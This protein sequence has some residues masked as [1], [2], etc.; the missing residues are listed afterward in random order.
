MKWYEV[1][2]KAY[3]EIEELIIAILE[4]FD[5]CGFAIDDN[6]IDDSVSWDYID[7]SFMKRDYILIKVYF[8]E[9]IDI[10]EVIEEIKK[11]LNL[12][13]NLCVQ[14]KIEISYSSVEEDQWINEWK[15]Y[16]NP[17]TIGNIIVSTS[18]DREINNINNEKIIVKIDPG[19]AFGTG[20]HPTTLMCIEALQKYLKKGMDVIDVGTGSGI[21][22]IVAKKLG[23]GR[24]IA[25]D[26][27]DTAVN[28]AKYNAKLNNVDIEVL[29]NDLISGIKDQFDIVIA[30]IIAEVIVDLT[31]KVKAVLKKGGIYIVSGILPEKVY[32]VIEALE[33]DIFNILE[34]KEKDNWYS[35]VSTI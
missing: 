28:V 26:I 2:I 22:S 25:I 9:E 23:A 7:E 1:V 31:G 34:I 4:E 10:I 15:K 14:S 21:L 20:S 16:H 12:F 35:I 32:S 6:T 19:M 3:K 29:K 5:H 11:K 24:V 17:V 27:D 18:W 13:L 30:N 8:E 33:N